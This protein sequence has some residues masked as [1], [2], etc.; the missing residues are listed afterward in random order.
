MQINRNSTHIDNV[1]VAL[2]VGC[3]MVVAWNIDAVAAKH[4]NYS[5]HRFIRPFIYWDVE[6][7]LFRYTETDFDENEINTLVGILFW[8]C[9]NDFIAELLIRAYE[10]FCAIR[11]GFADTTHN[12]YSKLNYWITYGCL[13]WCCCTIDS[14]IFQHHKKVHFDAIKQKS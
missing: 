11:R 10:I 8:G 9:S 13:L 6:I 4:L 12:I 14:W 7:C 1:Y 2:D 5:A 3:S